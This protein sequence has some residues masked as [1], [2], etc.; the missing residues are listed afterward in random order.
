MRLRPVVPRPGKIV[1]IGLNY[2][3]HV[4]EGVYEPPEY[5]VLFP[6]FAETLVARGA[7]ILHPAGVVRRRTTRPSS[8]S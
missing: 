1:C 7:P 3:A 5:P 6:K 2:R 8:P 4:D